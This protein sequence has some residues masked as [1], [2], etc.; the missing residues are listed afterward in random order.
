MLKTSQLEIFEAVAEY[1]SVNRASEKLHTSQPY[2]SRV[3]RSMEEELGKTLFVRSVRGVELTRDGKF[4]YSYA[5]S[6]L[7]DLQKIDEMK[8]LGIERLDTRL[9]IS[10]YS[11][12]IRYK[13]FSDFIQNSLSDTI[14]L[15]VK[16]GTLEELFEN[17]INGNSEAGVAVINDIEFPA[18]KSAAI[19]QNMNIEIWDESPLYVHVGSNHPAYTKETVCMKDLLYSTYVHIPLD[20]YSKARL[21]IEID[22]YRLK[23]FKQKMSVDNYRFIPMLIKETDSFMF[24]NKWQLDEMNR[25]GLV[26]RQVENTDMRMHFVVLTKRSRLSKETKKALEML[27]TACYITKQA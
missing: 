7:S 13:L 14:S 23:E 8:N 26:N 11:L 1:G 21:D 12:F 20:R 3:I 2:I 24:G 25:C 17:L 9:Q 18:V 10:V 27:K 4:L 6:I 19:A 15:S 16:E 5:K 22:G